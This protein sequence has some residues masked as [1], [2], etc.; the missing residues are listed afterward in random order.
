MQPR[1]CV[2]GAGPCGL[3]AVKNLL[4]AG[5]HDII[6]YEEN[7]GI[8]GNW[9]FTDDP[10]R[11]SVHERTRIISSRRLSAFEDFPMP[12]GYPQFPSHRQ[13]LAYFTGYA[14][15]F[16][17]EPHIRLRS[18]VSCCELGQDRRWTVRVRANGETRTE[19]FDA[20]LVC[21]G[22]HREPFVPEFPG[23]FTGTILHSS[24][25][26]RPD[27]YRGRRVLVVGAGNSAADIAADVAP[28]AERAA[29]SMREGAHFVPRLVFGMPVD[30]VY[31]FW[32][33]KLPRR[34]LRPALRLWLRL[35]VGRW[36]DYG[37]QRPAGA[38][39]SKPPTVN[40]GVL[41]A[42][43]HGRLVAR[44]GID[45]FDGRTV[46]FAGGVREEFDVIIMATGFRP[47]VA[48]LPK[49]FT[50]PLYLRMMYPAA[51][52]LFFIGRFQPVGCIWRLADLQ[53]R[54]AALHL[55]GALPR[56]PDLDTRVRHPIEVD[57][58]AFRRELSTALA[59]VTTATDAGRSLEPWGS[60]DES[61]PLL[62]VCPGSSNS[63][64]SRNRRSVPTMSWSGCGRPRS[65]GSHR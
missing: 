8:G 42:L 16:R 61:D 15:T 58:H 56:P 12:E 44:R 20:V 4:Q 30:V 17:I 45:R 59:A 19:H 63:Q 2:I 14:R 50:A 24:S 37:L 13:M 28:V 11:A 57:Y 7:D 55:R 47:G 46:H 9:A 23:T 52:G 48:F 27:P 36:E 33:G 38:P 64:T 21:T 34:L 10:E 53:A 26:K 3:T 60:S 43:R 39:L 51:P 35:A 25:Y 1:I 54:V 32:R 65:T 40:S 29:L 22:H 49:R 31:S 5:F 41:D 62:P 18:H 6:C